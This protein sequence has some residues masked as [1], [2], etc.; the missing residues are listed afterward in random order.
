M[1]EL[2]MCSVKTRALLEVWKIF[3]DAV[4]TRADGSHDTAPSGNAEQINA[5]FINLEKERNAEFINFAE[6]QFDKDNANDRLS[7]VKNTI[8]D[9]GVG[10]GS[11]FMYMRNPLSRVV[12]P[13][14]D[15]GGG[16][17]QYYSHIIPALLINQLLPALSALA[18][19]LVETH[20]LCIGNGFNPDEV[21]WFDYAVPPDD[22][23]KW[24]GYVVGV[25]FTS[26]AFTKVLQHVQRNFDSNDRKIVRRVCIWLKVYGHVWML[27][28][29]VTERETFCFAVDNL[30][31]SDFRDAFVSAFAAKIKP[32]KTARQAVASVPR[33]GTQQVPLT[34][35]LMCVSFMARC[36]VYLSMVNS[37]IQQT[38][39]KLFADETGITLELAAYIEFE[40]GLFD[41]MRNTLNSGKTVWLSPIRDCFVNIA[42]ICLMTVARGSEH[43]PDSRQQFVYA[44]GGIFQGK[45]PGSSA[46]N[47]LRL[48]GVNGC[49]VSSH[50]IVRE[51]MVLL[52]GMRLKQN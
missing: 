31:K 49:T 3:I 4:R 15:A 16:I 21:W 20:V 8:F 33:I 47:G 41:F 34:S 40:K 42:D 10:I 45:T 13:V 32:Q 22:Y 28:M 1:D 12:T 9:N 25:I 14:P 36:T 44:G 5:E 38:S 37:S 30:H 19:N 46:G 27:V 11:L 39:V 17:D 52:M 7:I 6:G 29:E 23:D 2:F 51:C 18:D 24:V 48:E 43:L 50:F 26:T 35:D